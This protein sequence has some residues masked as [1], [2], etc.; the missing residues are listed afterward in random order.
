MYTRPK[1][2]F[3]P[4]DWKDVAV[5]YYDGKTLRKLNFTKAFEEE[6]PACQSTPNGDSTEPYGILLF[7]AV[8]VAV[9]AF[10]GIKKG[11]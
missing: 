2:P 5:F 8:L 7:G 11:S 6:L 9:L 10:L 4:L 3:V 1:N